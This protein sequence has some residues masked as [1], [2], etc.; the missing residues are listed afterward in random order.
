MIDVIVVDTHNN[1]LEL[2]LELDGF[3]GNLG[4]VR[5]HGWSIDNCP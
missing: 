2:E 1:K 3:R 4:R 5:G